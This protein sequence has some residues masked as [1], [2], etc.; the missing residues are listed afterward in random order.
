MLGLILIGIFVYLLATRD[1][2]ALKNKLLVQFGLT[3]ALGLGM[4]VTGDMVEV[5]A[6]VGSFMF[7]G[8]VIYYASW[9]NMFITLREAP[10][11]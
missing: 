9:L 4:Q 1:V 5:D 7:V 11:K 2:G 3:L 6:V 8:V 10:K